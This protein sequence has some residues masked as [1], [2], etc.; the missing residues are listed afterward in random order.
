M[1][2]DTWYTVF[3]HVD[4]TETLQCLRLV[5]RSLNAHVETYL[6]NAFGAR[7]DTM[8]SSMCARECT[9]NRRRRYLMRLGHTTPFRDTPRY[10]CGQCGK[11][12]KE[13]ASC[14]RCRN[15][16]VTNDAVRFSFTRIL[17]GPISAV[18]VALAL[19]KIHRVHTT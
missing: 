8:L 19:K 3:E 10:V 5:D 14:K 15:V 7:L 9:S 17:I 1:D 16:V 12:V 4:D 18:V 13:L 11:R 2:D 6:E